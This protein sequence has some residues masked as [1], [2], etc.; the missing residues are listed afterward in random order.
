MSGLTTERTITWAGTNLL[1]E[2]V[3]IR[4]KGL[5]DFLH[6][7][8]KELLLQTEILCDHK[9]KTMGVSERSA[10]GSKLAKERVVLCQ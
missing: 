1:G 3:Q 9:I 6:I 7:L 2:R 8:G 10:Q 5:L 4:L